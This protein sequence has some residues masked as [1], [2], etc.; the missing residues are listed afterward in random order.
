M[1]NAILRGCVL[2]GS[3][4]ALIL[5]TVSVSFSLE[6]NK[7]VP[8]ERREAMSLADAVLKALQNNLDIHIG[9]D[10]SEILPEFLLSGIQEAAQLVFLITN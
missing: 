5:W 1:T 10:Q 3:A 7:P 2:V 8:T 9:R 4:T 6:V